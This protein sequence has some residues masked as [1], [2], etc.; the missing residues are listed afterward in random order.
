[1]H[2]SWLDATLSVTFAPDGMGPTIQ[3]GRTSDLCGCRTVVNAQHARTGIHE[4]RQRYWPATRLRDR[5]DSDAYADLT[6]AE[7]SGLI[8]IYLAAGGHAWASSSAHALT[9][10]REDLLRGGGRGRIESANL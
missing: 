1:M 9:S 10:A 2:D 5:L 4:S 8:S 3:M 6:R 7:Q